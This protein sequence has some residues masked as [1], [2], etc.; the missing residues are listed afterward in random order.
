MSMSRFVDAEP[1][2]VFVEGFP[3]AGKS[4]T[5]QLL[6]TLRLDPSS[7]WQTRR[8]PNARFVGFAPIAPQ[9]LSVDALARD[10]ESTGAA[11]QGQQRERVDRGYY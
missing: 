9:S 11:G 3:G 7:D 10:A 4:T 6:H 5:A 1:R 2:F 8:A